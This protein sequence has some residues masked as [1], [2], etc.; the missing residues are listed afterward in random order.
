VAFTC[1][2]LFA[3]EYSFRYFGVTEGL[4]NLAVRQIY[5]DRPGFLWVSTENGIFRY[6][7][8]RF[9]GFGPAQGIPATSGAAF[10]EAPDGSL[11]VGGDFGL[12]HQ[13]GNRFEKIALAARTVSWAQGIQSDGRGHTLIGTDSGLMELSSVPGRD[14]FGVRRFPQAAGTSGPEANGV[15]VDGDI[16]WYG[17]GLELCRTDRKGTTVL[18]RDRGLPARAW[19]VIRK[20]G[21]GNLWVRGKNAGVFVL[22]SGQSMFRRPDS[23]VPFGVLG[24][25][26]AVDADGRMLFPSSEGLLIRGQ[27]GWQKIARSAGLRGTVY[28][29]FEDRQQSLWI[30]LAGRGL[31]R[32]RGYRQWES[33]T[34]E[35]GLGS[36]LVY[37][38]LPLADGSLWVATEGGLFRGTKGKSGITWKKVIGVGDFPV[39]SIRLAPGGDLWIGTET[40]GAARIHNATGKVEWF[41]EAQGLTGKAPYTL[42]FDRKQRLWAA[43]DTGL[44][45]AKPPYREFSRVRE[46]PSSRFW[47]V[48]EAADGTMWAGGADGLFS[49]VAGH[50]KNYT[51]ADGLSN[52]EVISLGSGADGRIWIGYRHGGGIDRIHLTA[53]GLAIEKAVQRHGT[54]GIVYFLEFDALGRLWAGTERGVDMWDGTGW[55]HYDSSNGL[56]W[57]DCNL[58]AFA[59]EADGTV[60]IGTSGG[61]SR[62]RPG[63]RRSAEFLP[64]VVFTKLVMGRADVSGQRSPSVTIHSNALK[65]RYS[66]LNAPEA[67]RVVFRYRLTPANSAWTETVQRELE[68]AELAPGAYKLEVEARDGEGVWSGQRA[69]FPFEILTPWY[70]TWWSVGACVLIPLLMA[71]LGLRL[72]MVAATKREGELV[73]IVEEKTVDL[74]RVNEELLRLSSLDP[75]TGLANRRVFDQTLD[76][77]CARAKRNESAVSLVIVD[78]DHFKALNDSEGHQRGDEYLVLVGVELTRLARRQEDVV[79]RYGGEEFALILPETNATDAARIAESVRVAILRRGLPHLAS[80]V[81]A[82]VTV[83]VGVSTATPEWCNT[84]DQ[85]IAAA[86]EALYRAKRKGRNRVEVG[87]RQGVS[88]EVSNSAVPE[89]A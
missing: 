25:V 74:R 63:S 52:Q 50:W 35:G 12:Y 62:F 66:V 82:V 38:I 84:P 7:G 71:A 54:D 4:T 59:A 37:E 22:P 19:L 26:P 6:D 1:R 2:A 64:R 76:K 29:A 32:W 80:P 77:E 21:D 51:R 86:D 27:T 39:H 15:S 44:F 53:D 48:A 78:V 13:T 40:H 45:M 18:G 83:S 58:N 89:A 81:A 30:G 3:Q 24:G 72:R 8:E 17:C 11:L 55:S 42:R 68:F 57:D 49:Y 87:K 34:S 56:V 28:A 43:T 10:G 41:G 70:R 65:A 9:E 14:Q 20:D 67:N 46:L 88:R 85:L 31:A 73:R 60:W 36:D 23:P 61:L 33:Y 75:L 79:A 69:E 16:V 47:T 5:Q